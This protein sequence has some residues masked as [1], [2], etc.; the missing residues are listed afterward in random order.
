MASTHLGRMCD[1]YGMY[2]MRLGPCGLH[3]AELA[4]VK[5]FCTMESEE[6]WVCCVF[7]LACCGLLRPLPSSRAA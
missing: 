2:G 4:Y 3:C 5:G 7:A 6:C 1:M